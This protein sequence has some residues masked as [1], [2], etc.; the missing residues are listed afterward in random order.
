MLTNFRWLTLLAWVFVLGLSLTSQ[1]ATNRTSAPRSELLPGVEF[2]LGLEASVGMKQKALRSNEV[3]SQSG[4]EAVE[5]E[6]GAQANDSLLFTLTGAS[7]PIRQQQEFWVKEAF[8]TYAPFEF[9]EFNLGQMPYPVGFFEDHEF[10]FSRSALIYQDIYD[11]ERDIDVGATV[12]VSWPEWENLYVRVGTF[13]GQSFRSADGRRQ[14]AEENPKTLSLG[15]QNDLSLLELTYL[16]RD[17]AFQDPVEAY[18]LSFRIGRTQQVDQ[19]GWW[20]GLEGELWLVDQVPGRERALRSLGGY[21][22]PVVG[23]RNWYAGVRYSRRDRQFFENQVKTTLPQTEEW[24]WQ[25]GTRLGPYF[26]MQVERVE[27]GASSRQLS[28]D[29]V[30]EWVGRLIIEVGT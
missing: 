5:L 15:F 3:Q 22:Y 13:A 8:L 26:R 16:T 9:V 18:G 28:Q 30:K 12:Q 1:A 6:V 23:W 2:G 27:Q 21:L 11:N 4:L 20:S 19:F 14:D 10:R 7:E 25:A 17:M 29:L 24:L